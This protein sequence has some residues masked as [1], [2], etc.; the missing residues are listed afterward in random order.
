VIT[1][2]DYGVGNLGSLANMCRHLQI[3]ARIESDVSKIRE[4]DKL[5]LPGVGAFDTAMQKI[6][7]ISGL[8][9]A[10]EDHV[11]VRQKPILG[12]CLGMQ[13][14]MDSSEEGNLAGLGWIAGKS[15]RFLVSNSFKVPHVGWNSAK[16]TKYELMTS[17]VNDETRFY[18]VH[19][20]Y[21]KVENPN[22]SLMQTNYGIT[23][24][25]GVIK[26]NIR[27]VQFHP[28]KSHK[29]GMKLLRNF[30]EL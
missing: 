20:Y 12:I 30:S 8:R 4:T 24:D 26:D 19:S 27:G 5:I 15:Y 10:L 6:N 13:L 28:E 21:V 29:F 9:E 22:H 14:M 1:I 16:P 11:I 17:D 18:F 2:V 7:G 23:F 3:Q 25:S